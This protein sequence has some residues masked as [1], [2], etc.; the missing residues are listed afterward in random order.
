MMIL[1]KLNCIGQSDDNQFYESYI[2]STCIKNQ[3]ISK[4]EVKSTLTSEFKLYDEKMNSDQGLYIKDI[5]P[6]IK[7]LNLKKFSYNHAWG[8]AESLYPNKNGILLDKYPFIYDG[9]ECPYLSY[10]VFYYTQNE[11]EKIKFIL[12]QWKW[13]NENFFS[14]YNLPF[15]KREEIFLNKFHNITDIIT[16]VIGEPEEVIVQSKN[17]DIFYDSYR[18]VSSNGL[19]MK[20][21][22]FGNR[23]EFREIYLTIYFD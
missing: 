17:E 8:V 15:S 2:D 13:F 1:C 18:W 6:Y 7:T 9:V 22:Y 11:S 10:R 3:G 12:M 5:T 19:N 20:L 16:E 21:T 14:D 4:K 23:N